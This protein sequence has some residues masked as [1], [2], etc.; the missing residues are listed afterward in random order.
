MEAEARERVG[1]FAKLKMISN[2]YGEPALIRFTLPQACEL[3]LPSNIP[4]TGGR[5]RSRC[6]AVAGCL[7]IVNV[8][9]WTMRLRGAVSAGS[10]PPS[11]ISARASSA[12]IGSP[13]W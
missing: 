2:G 11:V 5:F 4:S 12:V 10:R 13:K 8:N 7:E 1:T 6:G 3:T 9:Y